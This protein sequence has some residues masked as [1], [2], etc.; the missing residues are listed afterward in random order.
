[1]TRS[2]DSFVSVCRTKGSVVAGQGLIPVAETRDYVKGTH[3]YLYFIKV[4]VV[5]IKVINNLF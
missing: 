1:M 3:K 4:V 2:N 5:L